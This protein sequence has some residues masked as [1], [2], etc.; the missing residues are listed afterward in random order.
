[1]FSAIGSV[2]TTSTG[3]FSFAAA[4]KGLLVED[5]DVEAGG[6]PCLGEPLGERLRVQVVRR[7]VD[8]I[9]S[10]VDG[11]GDD[12]RPAQRRPGL[13]ATVARSDRDP[14]QRRRLR[15]RLV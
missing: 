13:L 10:E 4:T 12:L 5:L 3:S 14:A 1:M 15:L 9:A 2:A 6:L 7:H 11:V 8:Q